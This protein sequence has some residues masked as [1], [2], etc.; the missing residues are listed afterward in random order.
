[1]V[2]VH[3]R[4]RSDGGIDEIDHC[5]EGRALVGVAEAPVRVVFGLAVSV[6]SDETEQI[7]ASAFEGD[8]VAFEIEED[9]AR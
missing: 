1:M 4:M 6:E 7:F 3:V 5:L 2:D 8:V 9:V